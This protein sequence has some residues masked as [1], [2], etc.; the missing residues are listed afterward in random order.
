MLLILKYKHLTVLNTSMLEG[1]IRAFKERTRLLSEVPPLS[2]KLDLSHHY[3]F[4][5]LFFK[6]LWKDGKL[7]LWFLKANTGLN[8][9]LSAIPMFI[10]QL[11]SSQDI[12]RVD[13]EGF[14]C[15]A[16]VIVKCPRLIAFGGS[17]NNDL[18]LS[19]LASCGLMLG[20]L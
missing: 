8:A 18:V 20:Y 11:H 17:L 12:S 3:F 2:L 6:F 19:F 7:P 10:Q 15:L 4:F 13:Y 14:F 9:L 16:N 5:Y 1:R